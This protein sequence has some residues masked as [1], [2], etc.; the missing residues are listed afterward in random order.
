M[1]VHAKS[2]RKIGYGELAKTAKVPDPLPAVTK[3][4]LKPISQFRL[5]GKDIDRIEGPSKV[6]GTAQYGIDVQL[7]DMLYAAV[8]YP[9]VQH[10]KAEHVDD[11]A[12]KA[13]KGVV[14]IVPLPIGVGVIADTVEGA[15]RAKSLLK[16]TWT[17][18]APGQTYTRGRRPRRLPH[19]R[20]RLE[21]SPASRWSR[22]AMPTPR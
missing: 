8:L 17:K 1:V 11:A 22:R 10:E 20:R 12:A 16:V 19:H 13:V 9:D 21:P 15:M 4:E 2:N 7:P 14:K 5:I 18:S 6:N 3:E